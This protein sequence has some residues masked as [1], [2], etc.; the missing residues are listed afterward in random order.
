MCTQPACLDIFQISFAAKWGKYPYSFVFLDGSKPLS[1]NTVTCLEA[2][3]EN[4]LCFLF[5]LRSVSIRNQNIWVISFL[6]EYIFYPV[7]LSLSCECALLLFLLYT[8][9]H[10]H[11]LTHT[12]IRTPY[13]PL[14]FIVSWLSPKHFLSS[15]Y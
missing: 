7:L 10:G 2:I 15:T 4:S 5:L 13:V 11:A 8:H 6:L 1:I 3:R 14:F 12:L 9:T